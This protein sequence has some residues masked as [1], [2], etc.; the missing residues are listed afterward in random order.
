M[1]QLTLILS[2]DVPPKKNIARL[3]DSSYMYRQMKGLS[4]ATVKLEGNKLKDM[5]T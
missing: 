5:H 2:Q 3:S 4:E 1:R